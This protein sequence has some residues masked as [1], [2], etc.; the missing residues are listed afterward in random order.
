MRDE[1]GNLING[2]CCAGEALEYRYDQDYD[3]DDICDN[4]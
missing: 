1:D 4:Y 2:D 3:E